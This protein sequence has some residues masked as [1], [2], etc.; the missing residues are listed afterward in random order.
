MDTSSVFP[1]KAGPYENY[2]HNLLSQ[3]PHLRVVTDFMFTDLESSSRS[4][5]AMNRVFK[6]DIRVIDI[7][8]TYMYNKTAVK[9]QH[10]DDIKKF[11]RFLEEPRKTLQQNITRFIMVEDLSAKVIETLGSKYSVDPEFFAQHL[12]DWWLEYRTSMHKPIE[13]AEYAHSLLNSSV[14][15]QGFQHFTFQRAYEVLEVDLVERS[16]S[17]RPSISERDMSG[18]FANERFSA[19]SLTEGFGNYS[20]PDEYWTGE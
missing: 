4:A 5:Q 17:L 15:K 14:R 9:D 11:Q 7:T 12:G 16:N 20:V 8:N 6:T 18:R 19:I 1:P 2:I 3:W 13:G 10:F